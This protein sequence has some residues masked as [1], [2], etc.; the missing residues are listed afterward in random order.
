MHGEPRATIDRQRLALLLER[1]QARFA[2]TH[3]RSAQAYADG[4]RHLLGGVPMTW[5]SKAAGALPLYLDRARGARASG[6]VHARL[7]ARVAVLVTGAAMP[8]SRAVTP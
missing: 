8:H 5:M 2:D 4:R 1:E 3:P 7:R 6:I